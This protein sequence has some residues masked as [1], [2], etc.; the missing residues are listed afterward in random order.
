MGSG[1]A[2]GKPGGTARGGTPGFIGSPSYGPAKPPP[3]A[4]L[5]M[6]PYGESRSMSQPSGCRV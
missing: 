5:C 6:R 4:S 1:Y 3:Q 2:L